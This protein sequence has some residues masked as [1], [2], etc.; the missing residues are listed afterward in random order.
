MAVRSA[1]VRLARGV[2][3]QAQYL[4]LLEA[5]ESRQGWWLGHARTLFAIYDSEDLARL[6]LP[7]WTYRAITEV[8]AFLA[9]REAPRVFEFGSGASTVWLA[10][11][12]STLH[13]VEHDEEF[14]RLVRSMLEG[15]P[16]VT[17]HQVPATTAGASASP[18]TSE[19]MGHGDL[20]FTDYVATIDQVGGPFDLVVVDG[21][22]RLACLDR[23]LDHLA[24]GGRIL[25]DDVRRRRYRS[26]LTLKGTQVRV[27]SGAKPSL[28]YPDATALLRLRPD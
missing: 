18:T 3:R 23:A 5:L 21:R 9:S 22:A 8:E 11:R 25:F 15:L 19:R 13:T 10:R 27:L 17:L 6:D 20:D 7:W 26:A 28:P 24:P 1:Y 12:V 2:R 14:A 4:G 16:H